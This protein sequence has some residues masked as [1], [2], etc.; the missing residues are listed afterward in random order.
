[1]LWL[2]P[3]KVGNR[4][5][6]AVE[7]PDDEHPP[8]KI[9]A[10]GF[11]KMGEADHARHVGIRR[12]VQG[13]HN[14][15]ENKAQRHRRFPGCAF[16][17]PDD[18]KSDQNPDRTSRHLPEDEDRIGGELSSDER[19]EWGQDGRSGIELPDSWKLPGHEIAEQ[20]IQQRV[21]DETE[22]EK[23]KDEFTFG[24]DEPY[25]W[26]CRRFFRW[27]HPAQDEHS[28]EGKEKSEDCPAG[29][30]G[31]D[32]FKRN[33]EA[34]LKKYR[35]Y[36]AHEKLNDIMHECHESDKLDPAPTGAENEIH[37]HSGVDEADCRHAQQDTC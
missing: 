35:F 7:E 20:K 19:K 25:I 5:V 2:F 9:G 10:G 12:D 6:P 24:H 30:L 26:F 31:I 13:I 1:M 15:S 16:H 28:D 8:K 23:F 17:H 33:F 18:R 3:D 22:D 4:C 36:S 27:F 14:Q 34:R 21:D 37:D 32:Q 11:D 29:K